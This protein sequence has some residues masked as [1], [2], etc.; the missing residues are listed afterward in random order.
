MLASIEKETYG[1]GVSYYLFEKGLL[2]RCRR[3]SFE[4]QLRARVLSFHNKTERKNL[5]GDSARVMME[6]GAFNV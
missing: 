6:E 2:T 4:L 1:M 5:G 3:L